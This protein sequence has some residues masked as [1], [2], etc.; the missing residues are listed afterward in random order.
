V[1]NFLRSIK[2]GEHGVVVLFDTNGEPLAGASGPGLVAATRAVTSV[3]RVRRG[4]VVRHTEVESGGERWD[5]VTRAL[6]RGPGFQWTAVVA[7]PEQDFMG[8]VNANR[9]TAIAIALGGIALAILVG[10]LLSTRMARSLGDAT[11]ALD[12]VARFDLERGPERRRSVLREIAR[13][14]DAVGRVTASLR[15]FTRYAPEEIVREVAVSGREAML[16]GDKR[17]VSALFCDL[18]GFTALAEHLPAEEVVAILNDHFDLLVD[19]IS[20]HL[21][22]VVDFLGDAV[23]AV[24]GA[25]QPDPTHAEQ[26]VA[27]AIEMQRARTARNEEMRARGWPP[28]EM[29]IGIS[30]GPAVVGNMGALRRIKYGVVGSI[31]NVAARIESFTVGGQTL[32]GDFT[33]QVLGHQLVVDG[34]MEAEGKGLDAV[35]RIWEVLALRGEK[36]LVLPSPVRDLAELPA[37]LDASVRVFHGKQLDHQSHPVRLYRLGAGG[38]ELESVAPLS[39]FGSLQMLLPLGEHGEPEALDGKVIALSERDGALT[40]LVRFTGIDWDIHDRLEALARGERGR[41]AEN[42][43]SACSG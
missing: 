21:G 5:V 10:A 34:P 29:G 38:A 17:E 15:S 23:F 30:T 37:P 36:M 2:I 43:E 42:R 11:E 32:I 39:V 7:V 25:P 6:S 9:R 33:R 12:R 3:P 24:F 22:F 35:I 18:R 13:L 28:L 1:A 31:V 19:L 16:S 40:A 14:Q 41:P 27:C 26:A 8:A 4:A 20:R